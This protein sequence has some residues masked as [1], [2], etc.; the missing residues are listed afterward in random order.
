MMRRMRMLSVSELVMGVTSE[1]GT[2]PSEA[3][4][5][6]GFLCQSGVPPTYEFEATISAAKS[7]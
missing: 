4:P 1:S 5:S 2:P 6:V 3:V 7:R